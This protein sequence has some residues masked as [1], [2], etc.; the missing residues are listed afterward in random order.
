[1]RRRGP[2]VLA[3]GLLTLLLAGALLPSETKAQSV[4]DKPTITAVIPVG[5]CIIVRWT[6][7]A[8]DGGSA[9]LQY[10]IDDPGAGV[11][12]KTVGSSVREVKWGNSGC[13]LF[14]HLEFDMRV[15]ARNANGWGSWSD[16]VS[17]T[18][19]KPTVTASNQAPTSATISVTNLSKAP[20][21]YQGDQPGTVCTAVAKGTTSV[22]L[23]GLS[24]SN[25]Y[26]Y[27]VFYDDDCNTN[28]EL[29]SATFTTSDPTEPAK[30][31]APTLTVGDQQ[32]RVSWSAP[33]NNGSAITDYDVRYSSDG[34]STWTEWN[35][36]DDGTTRSAT[37]TGLTNGTTYQVQVRATN[38]IG[39]SDWSVSAT[40]TP[41]QPQAEVHYEIVLRGAVERA[42]NEDEPEPLSLYFP[43]RS[44]SD[45]EEPVDSDCGSLTFPDGVYAGL[46]EAVSETVRENIWGSYVVTDEVGTARDWE[47]RFRVWLDTDRLG[48]ELEG[49]RYFALPRRAVF[50]LDLWVI[51]YMAER[52]MNSV[53]LAERPFE[54]MLTVC[55]PLPLGQA[56]ASVAVW[57]KRE[58]GWRLLE[59]A[60]SLDEEQ[61]CG[62]TPYVTVFGL[63]APELSQ[64]P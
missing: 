17:S 33:E 31:D 44:L 39:V 29:N 18:P 1:M 11:G 13:T 38:T 52:G 46:D 58:W 12:E 60:V 22:D 51:Y 5:G 28:S 26:T 19:V 42:S 10:K 6:P 32:I 50:D 14:G 35:A 20:W 61:V 2:A 16:P 7:P 30:P 63:V 43:T 45:C 55:L 41:A 21:W 4:P 53:R 36:S 9:I 3:L 8:D 24:P 64:G 23:T 40:A 47:R 57:D 25:T 37:I 27:R 54:P 48:F 49:R 62:L 15:Q 59:S 56:E 34:G